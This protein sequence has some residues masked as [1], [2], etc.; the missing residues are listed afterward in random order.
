MPETL[1]PPP[2]T[3]D[4]E[5]R[6][7]TILCAD[8]AGYSRMMGEDEERTV[9]TFRGHREVFE[10]LV[11]QYRG[12]I[13][14]T[15][16]DALLAEF[17]SAVEAVR[18]ATDIQSALRSRNEHLPPAERMQFRI[19]INLGDVILQGGD[20]L[21]DGVNV[22]A[23]IQAATEPG[24]ICISGSV[25]DQIQDKL[26]LEFRPLGEMAYKNIAKPVRTY[27]IAEGVVTTRPRKSPA[28]TL[29]IVA[30]VAAL[31]GIGWFGWSQVE[32]QRADRVR[33]EEQL[34]AQKKAA[35]DAQ[36]A[37]VDARRE[38]ELQAQKQ[39]AEAAL[40][41]ARA[42]QAR[43]ELERKQ[44]ETQRAASAAPPKPAAADS[45]AA[46]P[47]SSAMAL[48]DGLYSGELCNRSS[49]SRQCWPVA[50]TVSKGVVE[51]SWVSRTKNTSSARGSISEG[52]LRLTLEGWNARGVPLHATMAGR[53]ADGAISA[54]GN[55]SDG[56]SIVG[57]WRKGTF[58]TAPVSPPAAAK[59]PRAA[60]LDGRYQGQ[61]C[62]Q[63]R[64]REQCWAAP[65]LVKDGA[66][67]AQ[68][69]T[70]RGEASSAE[71]TLASDGTATITVRSFNAR[72]E[73]VQ[74][75]LKGRESNGVIEMNGDWRGGMKIRG[76][77]SRAG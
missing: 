77:W 7:A 1:T 18:C 14:N 59:A 15:A 42:E 5:R 6:L 60:A 2:A 13:F 28:K 49:G 19:G 16:G 41:V 74:A 70:L 17:P 67:S 39:A 47:A 38:A 21:G 52:A 61:F 45:A 36:R 12:R 24:G 30:A 66:L 43:V 9:R 56:T 33:L 65:L 62:N 22:A 27:T 34:A 11:A 68:W 76:R 25:H 46:A 71:G 73:P 31:A 35:E 75:T 54:S 44:L 50:L 63:L 29:G 37:A 57:E 51:G 69:K 40:R 26:S 58:A 10:S 32:A 48:H 72:G 55:W 53:V 8:V 4:L 23:R 20:L 3:R 64:E